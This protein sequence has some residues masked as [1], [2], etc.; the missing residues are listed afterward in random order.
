[1]KPK[2]REKRR[3]EE[4]R[5]LMQR[6]VLL[7]GWSFDLLIADVLCP[8]VQMEEKHLISSEDLMAIRDSYG[9]PSSNI[10]LPLELY[11]SPRDY[12]PRHICLN[13]FMLRAGV[14]ISF[15]FEMTEALLDF[16]TSPARVT[17]HS[18]KVL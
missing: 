6:G 14:R 2:E 4:V 12:R 16:H 5:P 9:I 8:D 10:M 7:I 18:W 1:M 3:E 15:E 13:K 17:P 11:E